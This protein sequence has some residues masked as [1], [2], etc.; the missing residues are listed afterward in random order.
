MKKIISH[1]LIVGLLLGWITPTTQT[2][3]L[4]DCKNTTKKVIAK[5]SKESWESSK[6]VAGAIAAAIAYGIGNDLVTARVCPE[7]FT[8]GFHKNML[9]NG[10]RAG[11]KPAQYMLKTKNPTTIGF[12]W[13]VMATWW[14]GA[15]L[16]IPTA[17][18]ARVGPWP[19][20]EM[21]DL[22]KPLGVGL[23][24]LYATSLAAGSYGY[25]SSRRGKVD[26]WW[27]AGNTPKD[28]MH[29]YTADAYAHFSGYFG[30][31]AV[32]I[33]ILGWTIR[34]R[35]KRAQEEKKAQMNNEKNDTEKVITA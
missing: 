9:Q 22:I 12:Y 29:R 4:S 28:A 16:G 11:F 7:Y 27:Q 23:T 1:S 26:L 15:L 35:Y 18:A 5:V 20:L 10:A 25:I 2:V 21:K 19:K 30:G 3:A 6:I 24:G 32:A 8:E 17:L 14:F 34:E 13:G 33:G 31:A